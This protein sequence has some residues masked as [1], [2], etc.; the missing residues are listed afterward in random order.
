MLTK[1]KLI[2][3]ILTNIFL[4]KLL[5]AK[6]FIINLER[7]KAKDF[8]IKDLT[9]NILMDIWKG[10]AKLNEICSALHGRDKI[11]TIGEIDGDIDKKEEDKAK[12]NTDVYLNFMHMTKTHIDIKDLESKRMKYKGSGIEKID[13]LFCKAKL[14][15]PAIKEK[16]GKIWRVKCAYDMFLL[17][18]IVELYLSLE[19]KF[20]LI[21]VLND[22]PLDYKDAGERIIYGINKWFEDFGGLHREGYE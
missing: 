10:Q 3:L 18:V 14:D 5:N 1:K 2:L 11:P 20:E 19:S 7:Q 17:R 22:T 4:L 12:E 6:E 16:K 8:F 9:K 13:E 15:I 21:R